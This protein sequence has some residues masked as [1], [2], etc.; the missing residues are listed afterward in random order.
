MSAARELRTGPRRPSVA[1]A[2]FRRPELSSA[3][4]EDLV[5]F[6]EALVEGRAL[7]LAERRSLVEHIVRIDRAA[8]PGTLRCIGRRS[9]CSDRLAGRRFASLEIRE[10]TVQLIARHGLAGAPGRARG[11]RRGP[12]SRCPRICAS[13]GRLAAPDLIRGYY[14]SP[15]GWAVVGYQ[16]FPGRCGDLTPLHPTREL[17]LRKT[18]RTESS[19]PTSASSA[20]GRPAGSWRASSPVAVFTSSFW[21]PV[22]ATIRVQRGAYVRRYL[23]GEQIPWRTPLPDAGPSHRRR[24][25]LVFPR[26]AART[27]SRRQHAALGGVH[28]SVSRRR[29][30][31]ALALWDRRRLAD[32]VLGSEPYYGRAEQALGVAGR[33]RRSVGLARSTPYPLPAFPFSYSDGLFAPAC[34]VPRD[35]T[36]LPAPGPQLHRVRRPLRSVRPARR[37][38]SARP[39][40]RPASTSPTCP[41]AEATGNV[42]NPDGRDGPPARNRSLRRSE[43][44]RLRTAGQGRAARDRPRLRRAAG[45]VETARLL[46]LS[47]S[48]DFPDGLANRSGLVGR[49]FMSHPSVDVTGRAR[50]RVYPYRIGFSTAMSRQFAVEQDRAY[51]GRFL[52]AVP[53]L[54]GTHAARVAAA[55]RPVGRRS[56]TS[57]FAMSSDGGSG[58][59]S[60]ASSSPMRANSVSLDPRVRITSTTPYRTFATAS[61]V[62][63]ERRSRRPRRREPRS[64][65]SMGLTDV[66]S[67]GLTFAGHQIGT[68][69]MGTDPAHQRGG[70]EL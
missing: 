8:V 64:C 13:S 59:G 28:A 6:G 70:S 63:S 67:R 58:F 27:R 11:R 19:T 2:G 29:L 32:L 16:S 56:C 35:R 33:R 9:T 69:R 7:A 43:R 42:T 46:L 22:P 10:R 21:N 31:P 37:A 51:S 61:A 18:S 30:P 4:I 12:L 34:R 15:A 65:S 50:E 23:R 55:E 45:A 5:A 54:G 57:M 26:L 62:T 14:G 36:P 47:A 38:T 17:A 53:E 49:F 48:R 52:P 66:R 20:L 44:G 1:A 40:P 3:E 60:S 24:T 68:H 41:H 39:A 25:R